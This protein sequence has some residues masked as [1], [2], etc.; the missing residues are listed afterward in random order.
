MLSQLLFP[1][2]NIARVL[3]FNGKIRDSMESGE[4]IVCVRCVCAVVVEGMMAERKVSKKRTV[5]ESCQLIWTILSL[6]EKGFLL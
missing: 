3:K 6:D 1:F 4:C 2:Y 5:N